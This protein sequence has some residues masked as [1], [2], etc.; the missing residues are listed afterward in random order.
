[1]DIVDTPGLNDD[2]RMSRITEEIIPKLDVVIMVLV[3]DSPFS[4]SE[5]DFV[6]NKLMTSDLGRILFLVN[7][8]DTLRREQD[9][10]RAVDEIK[11]RIREKVLESTKR[12]YGED[13]QEYCDTKQKLGN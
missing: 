11:K 7:K 12:I 6:M 1:V 9:R 2:E 5:A 8:I 10:V 4:S 13:S 3:H